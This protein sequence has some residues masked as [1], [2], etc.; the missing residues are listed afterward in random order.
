MIKDYTIA[1]FRLRIHDPYADIVELGLRGFKPFVTDFDAEAK[2]VIDLYMDIPINI[3]EYQLRLLHEFDFDDA[4]QVCYFCRYDH[5]YLFYMQPQ[6]ISR[7]DE[8]SIFVREF[9]SAKVVSNIAANGAPDISL[10]RFGL[11]VMFG[12]A[13]N[14]LHAIAIHSSVIVK[15]GGAV[16]F[17]G[18]SGTGK[19]THTRLWRENIE[20]AKLLNDDSPIIRC[21]DGVPTVFG[22]AWSGK[23]PCYINKSF[24]IRGIVRLSQAPHNAMRRHSTIAALG[25]LLPSCPPSFAYDN[26]LQ[27]NICETLSEVLAKVPVYHL[28]CLPDAAAAQ[29]SYNTVFGRKE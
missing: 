10:L 17:L 28:E 14:P 20:G 15:D 21:V 22:S 26:E 11:W 5:G 24:P 1:D 4:K 13:I 8:K 16:M 25:A 7:S 23:T 19:S 9:G 6:D 18:E 29:L 27:D 3:D 2:P 12:V